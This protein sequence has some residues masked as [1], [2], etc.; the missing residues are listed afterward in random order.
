MGRSTNTLNKSIVLLTWADST[1]WSRWQTHEDITE[2]ANNPGDLITSVGI[3]VGDT[4]DNITIVQSI[5]RDNKNGAMRIPRSA[6]KSITKLRD[7]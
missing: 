6:I 1:S 7:V 2:F 4:K 5:S 3:I